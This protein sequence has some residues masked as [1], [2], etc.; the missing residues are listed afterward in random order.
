M[1]K[2]SVSFVVFTM[3]A[4]VV[5][6]LAAQ[7]QRQQRQ[8]GGGTGGAGRD[9]V[10][11]LTQKSVQDELKLSDDQ[12][13]KI[14]DL[15]ASR[16]GNGRAAQNQSREERQKLQEERAKANLKALADILKPD[17]LQRAKQIA[18]QQQG[19]QALSDPEVAAALKLTDEQKDK[20]K[21]IQADARQEGGQA[22]Q[23]GGNQEEA[24]KQREALRKEIEERMKSVLAADQKATWKELVGEPFK[25]ELTRSAR[26]GNRAGRG[27]TPPR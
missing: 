12:V 25:G 1:K 10:T 14:S 3:L 7:Q 27:T 5:P 11:L 20:F 15:A 24:R 6:P 2:L 8:R 26:G 22:R 13:K 21:T 17:Q 19:V 18:W 16:R 23:R 4:L 9:I